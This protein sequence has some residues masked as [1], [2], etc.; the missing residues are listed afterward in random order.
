MNDSSWVGSFTSHI[1]SFLGVIRWKVQEQ[2][3]EVEDQQQSLYT[4]TVAQLQWSRVHSPSGYLQNAEQILFQSSRRFEGNHG[5]ERYLYHSGERSYGCSGDGG[6]G[7]TVPGPPSC[8]EMWGWF[9][10]PVFARVSREGAGLSNPITPQWPCL[11]AHKHTHMRAHTHTHFSNSW[12]A[13]T[14]ARKPPPHLKTTLYSK[15][16]RLKTSTS[17]NIRTHCAKNLNTVHN[18][19]PFNHYVK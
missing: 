18:G 19:Q 4:V 10:R 16:S 15:T 11:N 17:Q 8:S 1:A 3:A 5:C 12:K 7:E 9:R 6:R 2:T 13:H 14:V